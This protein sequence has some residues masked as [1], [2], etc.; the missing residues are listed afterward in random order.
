MPL[1]FTEQE[2]KK[3]LVEPEFISDKQFSIAKAEAERDNK[4]IIDV[5]VAR[6]YLPDENL[7][8]LLSDAKGY[9]FVDLRKTVASDILLK[10]VPEN[11]ARALRAIPFELGKDGLHVAMADPED[12]GA[13][14]LLEKKTGDNVV[15]Y[16]ATERDISESLD[17]YRRGLREELKDIIAAAAK[18]AASG[19]ER[20]TPV[21]TVVDKLL[22]YGYV[23]KASDVHIE[24]FEDKTL[25]RY[26][27]DGILHDMV[28]LPK[29]I[30]DFVVTRVKILS[31]LRTDEH[32][33]AQDGKLQFNSDGQRVD[34]RVSV[35]PTVLGEK[36]V[37]R[38][39]A[40]K[41]RR[42]TLEEIGLSERDLVVMRDQMNKPWGMILATGPTGCGK[43]TTLYA[44]LQILNT[45]ERNISTIE[46]PVEYQMTGINQIQVNPKTNL[47]FASGLR[48]ILR[49]DPNIIM[50][51]EIRD[52]ETAGIAVNAALTGHLVLSTLHTNDAPTTLPRLLDMGV[53]PF[54]VASTVNVAIA[55]RLVRKICSH[56]IFSYNPNE[57]EMRMLNRDPKIVALFKK[58]GAKEA[59]STVLYRGKG[60]AVCGHTGHHGRL[61]LFEVM[62]I[63]EKMRKLIVDRADA[64][65]LRVAAVAEGMTLMIE[66]GVKKVLNGET[67]LEEVL[68][69]VKE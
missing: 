61:A 47:T 65:Q 15:P 62:V 14:L 23:N 2:L 53:E 12:L 26:R 44:M 28:N 50:V 21:I 51:G 13:I 24:P 33:S 42:F 59:K 6:N 43:T 38:I 11:A 27:I 54:L 9:P 32:A 64:D 69:A 30:H 29:N 68:R 52:A 1:Q 46:D 66:D 4:N 5:I 49:Q 55:Q 19:V 58:A 57:D 7:G 17:R 20:E 31:K 25:V 18:T 41:A 48:S 3:I 10:L 63:S 16:F 39:L 56:C 36:V 60:C 34:V 67:T 22:E 45:R 35:A 37:M 40:E 8:Q